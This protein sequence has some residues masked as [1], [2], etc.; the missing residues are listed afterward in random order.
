MLALQRMVAQPW[1]KSMEISV[2]DIAGC[3][4]AE[5]LVAYAA[6][7]YLETLGVDRKHSALRAAF[8]RLDGFCRTSK[9][10]SA[11]ATYVRIARDLGYRTLALHALRALSLLSEVEIDQPFFPALARFD[12]LEVG[13]AVG[14]WFLAAVF[15]QQ[16]LLGAFSSLYSGD[17]TRLKWLCENAPPSAEIL[18]RTILVGNS[19]GVPRKDLRD[20]LARLAAMP[21]A[22]ATVW[23]QEDLILGDPW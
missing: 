16:E 21:S 3:P 8:D 10:P 5:A 12:A 2:D 11:L 20:C 1:A 6:Y 9:N 7:L 22:N 23:Q 19:Q 14:Q 4:F 15:E 18:R 17:I 13:E